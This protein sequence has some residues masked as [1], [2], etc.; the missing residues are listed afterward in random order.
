MNASSHL[1]DAGVALNL[2]GLLVAAIALFP[3]YWMVLTSF[4]RGVDIQ[5]PNPS[6]LPFPGRS[7]TT[8]RCS[9]AT[10]SGPRPATA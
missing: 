1:P 8:A 6:F 9:S 2:T 3:V 5:S 7:T 4:R 10:S